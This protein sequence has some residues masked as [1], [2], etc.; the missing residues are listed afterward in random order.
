M[1]LSINGLFVTLS[2]NMTLSIRTIRTEYHYAECRISFIVMLIVIVLS[3]VM[4][5]VVMLSVVA[6]PNWVLLS[7][8]LDPVNTR[9]FSQG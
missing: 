5:N 2:L 3:V 7:K 6:P 1:T 9:I 4:L 8:I